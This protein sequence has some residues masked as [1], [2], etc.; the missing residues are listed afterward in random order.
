MKLRDVLSDRFS[1]S[2]H[3][4]GVS[5]EEVVTRHARLSWH[6]GWNDDDRRIDETVFQLAI[7]DK[8]LHVDL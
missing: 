1:Q 5:V 7:A 8:A 6:A 4:G 3:D 2:V